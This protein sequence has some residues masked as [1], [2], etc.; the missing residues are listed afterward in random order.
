MAK[1]NVASR[2]LK[3]TFTLQLR[4]PA[5]DELLFADDEG[6]EPVTIELFGTASKQYRNAM[7]EMMRKINA[8]K[9]KAASPSVQLEEGID[10]L[11]ACSSSTQH[12]S[13]D[14]EDVQTAIQFRNMYNRADLNWIKKQVDGAVSDDSNFLDK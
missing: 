8:R 1:F 14:D 13:V 5:S 9:G 12:L 4:D 7:N 11:V 2:S 6:L 10:F 3:D